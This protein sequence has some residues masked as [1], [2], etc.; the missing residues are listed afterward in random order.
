MSPNLRKVFRRGSGC[1]TLVAQPHLGRRK[2][3]GLACALAAV[4]SVA[5]A[6][7]AFAGGHG[8]KMNINSGWTANGKIKKNIH[9]WKRKHHHQQIKN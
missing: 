5:A 4:L 9:H 2:M 8:Y 6:T 7:S 3:K 1:D